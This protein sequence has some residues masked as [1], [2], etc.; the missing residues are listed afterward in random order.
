[1][2]G[3]NTDTDS[4]EAFLLHLATERR[5]A[6]RT[7]KSYAKDLQQLEAFLSD[8]GVDVLG[9]ETDD[10]RSFLASRHKD[11]SPRSVARKLAAIRGLYKHAK[12]RGW[13]F[14]IWT[15][16]HLKMG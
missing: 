8:R 7:L 10:L 15:E 5:L 9:A 11:L 6:E 13:K 4:I 12:R 2:P 3:A 1:M 14:L 16:E